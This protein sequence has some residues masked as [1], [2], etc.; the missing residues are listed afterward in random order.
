MI[1]PLPHDSDH[2]PIPALLSSCVQVNSYKTN[3]MPETRKR[4]SNKIN[5][6]N[7]INYLICLNVPTH[8]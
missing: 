6:N 2:E 8:S 5:N 1:L 4:A 7:N 3:M